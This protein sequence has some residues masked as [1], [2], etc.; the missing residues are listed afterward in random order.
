MHWL[1]SQGYKRK[2]NIG[3]R[4]HGEMEGQLAKIS[5]HLTTDHASIDQLSKKGGV[6]QVYGRVGANLFYMCIVT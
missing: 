4:M 3:R 2:D 1:N 5:L 6:F